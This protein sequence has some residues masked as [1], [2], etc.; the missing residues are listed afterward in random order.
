MYLYTIGCTFMNARTQMSPH[1]YC[2]GS[3]SHAWVMIEWDGGYCKPWNKIN[4][5]AL[6]YDFIN[7]QYPLSHSPT[8]V[9]EGS[10]GFWLVDVATPEAPGVWLPRIKEDVDRFYVATGR[11]H[12]QP[13][14]QFQ[15]SA[16][17][18]LGERGS[19]IWY[20][21]SFSNFQR[22]CM[23]NDWVRWWGGYCTFIKS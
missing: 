20:L 5:L 8:H 18:F 2:L 6:I 16:H 17:H 10:F 15:R 22:K 3:L 7:V 23:S 13:S 14:L 11:R 4:K 12:N 19:D 1:S 21:M 9:P